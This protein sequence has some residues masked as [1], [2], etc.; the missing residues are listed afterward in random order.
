[1]II[2]AFF[3]MSLYFLLKQ[4]VTY[5]YSFTIVV[6]IILNVAVRSLLNSFLTPTRKIRR[7]SIFLWFRLIEIIFRSAEY[8]FKETKYKK[9]T[10]LSRASYKYII[11][12][13]VTMLIWKMC[14]LYYNAF[15]FLSD[16][17]HEDAGMPL[18]QDTR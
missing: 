5:L 3:S 11:F 8:D 15:H 16:V 4:I 6:C 18:L 10:F 1:M 13:N 7:P 2:P 9:Q 14:T 17:S 12:I